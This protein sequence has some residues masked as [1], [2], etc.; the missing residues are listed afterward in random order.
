MPTLEVYESSNEVAIRAA[1][2]TVEVLTEAL[3]NE[4]SVSFGLAGGSLPPKAYQILASKYRKA[5]DWQ[6]VSF[7][8]GDERCVPLDDPE[9]SW[10][11]ALP[12]LDSFGIP[13]SQRLRPR[14]DLQAEVAATDY[15][16]MLVKALGRNK[17]GLRISLLWK[18][19]GEDGH[20][21]SL[22]PDHASIAHT[23]SLVIPVHNSPK[24]PPD[25]ISLSLS[26]LAGTSRCLA[27]I[28]GSGK[29]DVV[30]KI[31]DGDESFPIVQATRVIEQAGGSVTWLLDSDAAAS[32][33][34]PLPPR[35]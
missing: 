10:P 27:L 25:R 31:L 26:A 33:N 23:D 6:K 18:G 21:L 11:A 19:M 14:S 35:F 4:E 7:L 17:S 12:M 8:I 30:A 9:S 22:F 1:T 32:V 29:A 16:V 2:L 15:E 24:P 20:T 34:Q 13:E 28:T 3:A 5:L